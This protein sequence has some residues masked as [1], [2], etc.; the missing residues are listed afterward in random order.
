MQ[1][2]LEKTADYIYKKFDDNIGEICIVLPNRRAG[3][4]L[5]KYLAKRIKKTIWSP[6][7]FF[8]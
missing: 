4:F 3:L 7:I 2:F 1:A 8:K 5:K 6:A